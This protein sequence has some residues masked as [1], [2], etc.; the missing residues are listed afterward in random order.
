MT[1]GQRVLIYPEGHLAPV[2]YHFKYKAGIW[3][4]YRDMVVPVVPVATNL[5][6]F[7]HQQTFEKTRGVAIIEFLDPIEPGLEKS[8][9]LEM[10][11]QRVE[12]ATAKLVAEARGTEARLAQLIPDPK[13][14]E[15]AVVAGLPSR[16]KV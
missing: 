15:I 10:L 9:F 2:D 14:G 11:T 16:R 3:H 4:M 6:L 7:W 12:E 8:E 5:G 13:K 1:S